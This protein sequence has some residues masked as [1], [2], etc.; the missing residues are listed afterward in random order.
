MSEASFKSC[1]SS[2][3]LSLNPCRLSHLYFF[4]NLIQEKGSNRDQINFQTGCV[5][6]VVGQQAL[7]VS[8]DRGDGARHTCL[9]RVSAEEGGE[10]G[11]GGRVAKLKVLPRKEERRHFL[12]I[13]RK[14]EKQAS[15][16]K[17]TS[18]A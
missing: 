14:T 11:E 17:A 18:K 13:T 1:F 7:V 9:L 4:L 3:R 12:L 16:Q 2:L 10:G 6:I 8:V 5:Y 15:K